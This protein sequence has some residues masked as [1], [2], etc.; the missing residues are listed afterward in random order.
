MPLARVRA[1]PMML[2]ILST[3][4]LTS[5][6]KHDDPHPRLATACH[7]C[8]NGVKYAATNILRK[9]G[10]SCPSRSILTALDS[11]VSVAVLWNRQVWVLYSTATYSVSILEEGIIAL[12]S[13]VEVTARLRP[14][15]GNAAF[16]VQPSHPAV[17]HPADQC[18]RQEGICCQEDEL[19][20]PA[21]RK[22][23][24]VAEE[25]PAGL[26]TGNGQHG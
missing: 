25:P 1:V 24:P 6:C 14:H 18:T 7:M 9:F 2:W 13:E 8:S 23:P 5:P 15:E 22:D 26:Y 3:M 20:L 16:S 21:V 4:Y 17:D 19:E 10:R 12:A 11:I